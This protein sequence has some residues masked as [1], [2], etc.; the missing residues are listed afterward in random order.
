MEKKQ[1]TTLYKSSIITLHNNFDKTISLFFKDHK[2]AFKEIDQRL[3]KK[4][5]PIKHVNN[6]AASWKPKLDHPRRNKIL[7]EIP[8]EL[9]QE[10]CIILSLIRRLCYFIYN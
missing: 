4:R 3:D 2:L 6:Q 1:P 7:G 5:K 10:V 9:R 8:K